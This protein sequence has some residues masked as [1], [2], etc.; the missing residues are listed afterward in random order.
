M[1]KKRKKKKRKEK[2]K[3]AIFQIIFLIYFFLKD[4]SVNAFMVHS[5]RFFLEHS[6]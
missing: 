2:E 1:Q 6:A 5:K 3:K 4:S